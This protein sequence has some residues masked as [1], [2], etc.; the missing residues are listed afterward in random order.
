MDNDKV[1][2]ML[3]A[4][5][6]EIGDNFDVAVM[7]VK[8]SLDMSEIVNEYLMAH[9]IIYTLSQNQDASVTSRSIG[10]FSES[11]SASQLDNIMRVLINAGVSLQRWQPFLGGTV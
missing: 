6:F 10:D 3:K 7:M 8:Q 11:Y 2:N 5:N 1:K 9:A 4:L